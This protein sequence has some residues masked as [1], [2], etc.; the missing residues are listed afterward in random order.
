MLSY[1][2]KEDIIYIIRH[3]LYVYVRNIWRATDASATCMAWIKRQVFSGTVNIP[4]I[5]FQL[6]TKDLGIST[7][8]KHFL[9]YILCIRERERLTHTTHTHTKI[10][11]R[12][13]HTHTKL[14]TQTISIT[15]LHLRNLKIHSYT[16]KNT[17]TQTLQSTQAQ[18]HK[19]TF[20]EKHAHT[21]S[22]WYILIINP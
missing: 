11:K 12:N 6:P 20:Y 22:R 7:I 9:K 16:N 4:G 18:T 21:S 19:Y 17:C 14:L 1:N 15:H 8:L 5:N 13:T 3:N 10:Y 2:T